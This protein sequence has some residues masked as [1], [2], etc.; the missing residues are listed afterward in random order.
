MNRDSLPVSPPARIASWRRP[1]L[2]WCIAGLMLSAAA[3]ADVL[4]DMETRIEQGVGEIR[5]VF[6]VPVRYLKHFPAERGELLKVYLQTVGLD[7]PPGEDLRGYKRSPAM[8]LVPA[9]SVTYTTARNCY[10]AREPLCLDIQ[11]S[12]P[13]RYRLHPGEDGHSLLIHLLPDSDK[14]KKPAKP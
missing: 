13:V 5:L 1:G 2:V 6:S 11:F 4:E 12:Q 8:P 10:A 9:Y 7:A 14:P 3:H